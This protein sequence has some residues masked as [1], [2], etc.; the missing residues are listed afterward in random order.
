MTRRPASFTLLASAGEAR[1]GIL[2][3]PHGDVPTPCFMPVGTRATVRGVTPTELHA[4][5]ASMVLAN[6]Y[7]LWI[8]PGHEVIRAL[9][10]LHSF[11]GWEGPLLTDSGGYQ[12]F[13]LREHT[14]V[15]EDGVR[16]R[17]P[18]DGAYRTLTPEVAVEVQEALG[19]DVAMAFDECLEWPAPRARAAE[20]AARTTRWLERAQKARNAPERTALFGIVQGSMY[21]DLRV[22]HAQELSGMALDG[23]AVGG[24]SVG[25]E[26]ETMLELA[27]LTATHLPPDRVRYLMGV[28]TPRDIVEAVL[29]GLDLFDCVLPTRSGRHGQAFTSV[30]RLNLRNACHARDPD[31]LDP[32]CACEACTGFS[33]AYLRHLVMSEELLGRRLLTLHNLSYYQHLTTRLRAAIADGDATCLR[34]LREE[35]TRA[36]KPA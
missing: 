14:T 36:S 18:L 29:G 7:H 32:T 6:T 12:V 9:G 31:P 26:R 30:G 34:G 24:L 1:T 19:V 15:T 22:A 25:E 10:G 4:L 2:H 17:A 16:F 27:C 13:S 21:P 11:M 5:G 33:R 8:R 35:S 20:S 3:L 28:G 23:Y